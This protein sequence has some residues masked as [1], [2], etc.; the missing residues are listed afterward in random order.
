[1]DMA[2]EKCQIAFGP[3]FSKR[4]PAPQQSLHDFS[5]SFLKHNMGCYFQQ[6]SHWL[7][8]QTRAIEQ[9]VEPSLQKEPHPHPGARA[10]SPG[11]SLAGGS[12]L[13]IP[14]VGGLRLTAETT[15]TPTH[16]PFL[17]VEGCDVSTPT[18]GNPPLHLHVNPSPHCCEG[19]GG[20]GQ[21]IRKG[22]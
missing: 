19:L 10:E 7:L 18:P 22:D 14:A 8:L 17:C 12:E 2:T 1:M 13:L 11:G 16:R 21:E 9:V 4:S 3:S 15:Q 5:L 20:G 6:R